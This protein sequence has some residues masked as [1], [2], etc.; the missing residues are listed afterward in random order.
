MT[1][2]RAALRGKRKAGAGRQTSAAR[3][4][5]RASPARDGGGSGRKRA[6]TSEAELRPK[7]LAL[8]KGRWV[9]HAQALI[10]QEDA[11]RHYSTTDIQQQ[12]SNLGE[13]NRHHQGTGTG[14][15]LS[16]IHI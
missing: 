14:I 11:V 9:R 4:A 7:L 5:A 8:F 10:L 1:A 2:R 16:L 3:L 6:R 13:G 15:E 12:H